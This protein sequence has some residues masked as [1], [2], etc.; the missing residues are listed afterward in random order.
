[1]KGES[2]VDQVNPLFS[3]FEARDPLVN[4]SITNGLDPGVLRRMVPITLPGWGE[5]G[6]VE[7]RATINRLRRFKQVRAELVEL[8]FIQP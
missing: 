3:V 7:L 1:M 6:T 8:I 5:L 4:S 2:T